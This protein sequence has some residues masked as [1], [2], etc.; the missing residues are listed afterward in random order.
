MGAAVPVAARRAGLAGF[1]LGIVFMSLTAIVIMSVPATIAGLY[2][3]AS[4]PVR[5]DVIAL[6]VRLLTIAALFQV[7]DGAQTIA[8]GA[9]RGLK[10][11]RVPAIAAA[12]GYWGIGFTVAWVLGMR[13][14]LGAPGIWWGLAAGLAAVAILLCVRFW[15]LSG[16]LIALAEAPAA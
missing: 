10:D 8:A 4:D 2:I 12:I 5:G 14:G 7:F 3:T 1:G 13:L 6:A 9:L 16:R 11:T 15:R